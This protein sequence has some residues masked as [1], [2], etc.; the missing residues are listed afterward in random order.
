MS[1]KIDIPVDIYESD[2]EILIVVP[3][4][5]VSKDTISVYLEKTSLILSWSRKM[6]DL[7]ES[8]TP[9]QE[10]CFW[11][12]FCKTINLPQN[13]YFEKISSSLSKEN[14]LTIVVPKVII[15]E[16]LELDIKSS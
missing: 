14:I 4:W 11:W 5:W 9:V 13:V 12:N 6:S 10:E 1:E 7:K 16:K 8:L 3:L 2:Q 15:P